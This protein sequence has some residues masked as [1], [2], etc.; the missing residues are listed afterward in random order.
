[1]ASVIQNIV[2]DTVS[3]VESAVESTAILAL[4]NLLLT[5]QGARGVF[6]PVW[7]MTQ[8]AVID[9]NTGNMGNPA[10]TVA[11]DPGGA[12]IPKLKFNYTVQFN[13][14]A[15]I[16]A[17][18]QKSNG[19]RSSD[20]RMGSIYMDKMEFQVK[21]A[22]RP[23]PTVVYQDANFYNYRT[24]VAT[25]VDYGTCT[26]TFYDDV[27]NWAHDIYR[28]YLQ[29]ISPI[30][31]VQSPVYAPDFDGTAVSGS[32]LDGS[33]NVSSLGPLTNGQESGLINSIIV[34]HQLPLEYLQAVDVS[35]DYLSGVTITGSR[36]SL[37]T[38]IINQLNPFQVPPAVKPNQ[39]S[40]VVAADIQ[41]NTV[42]YVYMNPKIIN[43]N[44]DDLD[45]TQ[46]DVST[47]SLTFTY[48]TVYIT[49]APIAFDLANSASANTVTPISAGSG[50][51]SQLGNAALG[52]A[53]TGAASGVVGSIAAAL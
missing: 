39:F 12:N 41:A 2:S 5:R 43:F 24:K 23:N 32:T 34:V 8:A 11:G 45:M 42:Q 31:N 16:T 22:S 17:L 29:S 50:I 35:A 3:S 25:K 6:D 37:S 27:Q 49:N 9:P 44:L 18:L 10:Q 48:D 51:L 33:P 15:T 13:F 47:V 46:S 20:P 36:S 52:G 14:N 19:G 40:P 1:M 30:A 21:T 38:Q 7:K 53:V 26:I 4:K 28:L